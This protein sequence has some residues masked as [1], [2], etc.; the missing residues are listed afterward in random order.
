MNICYHRVSGIRDSLQTVEKYRIYPLCIRGKGRDLHYCIH[1][2]RIPDF[3]NEASSD[4]VQ[5]C[6]IHQKPI[7]HRKD[8]PHVTYLFT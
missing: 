2:V 6:S 1:Y 7:N 3:S 4:L 8:G 5:Y